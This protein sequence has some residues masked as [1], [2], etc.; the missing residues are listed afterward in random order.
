MTKPLAAGSV[1]SAFVGALHGAGHSG[2]PSL[3]IRRS[4][5]GAASRASSM[6]VGSA[7]AHPNKRLK[8]TAHV[9]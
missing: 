5:G 8:L 7:L 9:E 4:P 6:R 2:R 3:G 1:L